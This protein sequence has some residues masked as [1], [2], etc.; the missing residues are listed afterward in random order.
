MEKE[1][2]QPIM[3]YDIFLS[4]IAL[5]GEEC[6]RISR[7]V[8]RNG[9]RVER[10]AVPGTIC[11]VSSLMHIYRRYGE[12]VLKRTLRLCKRTW[13]HKVTHYSGNLLNTVAVLIVTYGDKFNDQ[14]FI[15][16][17][18]EISPTFSTPVHGAEY[19]SKELGLHEQDALARIMLI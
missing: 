9:L 5:K 3:P 1:V 15:K 4:G 19:L 2:K 7:I 8:K 10:T 16:K 14:D 6:V 13:K 17:F 12:N 11:C 18:R